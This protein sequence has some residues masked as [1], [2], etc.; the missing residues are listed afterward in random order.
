MTDREKKFI[1]YWKVKREA[2]RWKFCFVNGVLLWGI[3]VFAILQVVHLLFRE[4]YEFE[5]GRLVTGFIVWTLTG[6]FGFGMLMWWLNERAYHKLTTK[7][8]DK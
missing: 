4:E 2:G 7:N 6:F 8:P 5:T 3:P 1:A